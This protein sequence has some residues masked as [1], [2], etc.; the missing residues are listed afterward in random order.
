M[1]LSTV[2]PLLKSIDIKNKQYMFMQNMAVYS[3]TCL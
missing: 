1:H 2:L 3:E